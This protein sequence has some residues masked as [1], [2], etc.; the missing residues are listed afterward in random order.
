M[1]ERNLS[2]LPA[3]LGHGRSVG[4]TSN[5][6]LKIVFLALV[7]VVLGYTVTSLLSPQ[8][9]AFDLNDGLSLPNPIQ[10][11]PSYGHKSSNTVVGSGVHEGTYEV[12]H[13]ADS[14]EIKSPGKLK[15][16]HDSI[17]DK[18]SS[19]DPWRE[20][21]E[22]TLNTT[23][24]SYNDVLDAQPGNIT[25]PT[26]Q[27]VD[28]GSSFAGERQRIGKCTVIFGDN[29][30]YERALRTHETH[31]KM[32]GYPLH[33]LRQN[34]L[35]DVWTKPAY[36]LSLILRELAKP[37][38]ERLQWL[39]WVDADTIL[40]NPYIPVEIFL[41]PSPAFDDVH[42]MVSHDWNGLNNG[43]F[44]IRVHRWSVEL[45]SAIVA[46]RHY[47]P[48]ENLVF[49]DQSAMEFL[50]RQRKFK[51]HTVEAPQRWFNA[52]QGEHNETLAPFQVRRG[53]F[54]VHF[55]GVGDRNE[56]MTYWLERAEQH[57]PDWEIETQHTSYPSEVREFWGEQGGIRASLQY[58]LDAARAEAYEILDQ[59]KGRMKDYGEL[60]T[61][62]E[63]EAVR[64]QEQILEVVL[65]SEDTKDDLEK[66][67]QVVKEYETA[68]RPLNE[69]AEK[70]NKILMKEAHD[71]IFSADNTV[72]SH[73]DLP[74]S[75]TNLIQEKVDILK[76]LILQQPWHKEEVHTAIGELRTAHTQLNGKLDKLEAL[77]KEV[78]EAERMQEMARKAKEEEEKAKAA[79]AKKLEEEQKKATQEEE[80]RKA[81][82]E[83]EEKK[84]KLDEEAKKAVEDELFKEEMRKASEAIDA[85]SVSHT[86]ATL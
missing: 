66:I 35:E 16:L 17:V 27:L 63:R 34:I 46:F 78:E 7:C 10:E 53:D 48:D 44:P 15:G 23:T 85:Q 25:Q 55:A 11:H 2:P 33:I 49:R 20:K 12:N 77:R 56:R 68:A 58:K 14:T 65:I 18:L 81:K 41:P 13:S 31:N 71:A 36:I 70:A 24:S 75:E 22:S 45:L 43:V 3:W 69:Q 80:E 30:V 4:L 5:G 73:S 29:R 1:L 40:L 38:A 21:P 50:L 28:P 67:E 74:D 86:V 37:E 83:E 6:R 57:L 62:P 8:E 39:L 51:M 59:T 76:E 64:K 61:D 26:D 82:L 72:L 54:L 19:W 79:D 47:L 32:H 60:L 42:L 84:A 52:Y 9:Y